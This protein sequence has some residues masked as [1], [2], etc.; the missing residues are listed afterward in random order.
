M[1]KNKL[2]ILVVLGCL[3]CLVGCSA[4]LPQRD[5]TIYRCAKAPEGRAAAAYTALDSSIYVFCGRSKEHIVNASILVYHADKDSW[6]RILTSIPPR[7]HPTATTLNGAIYFGLGYSGEGIYKDDAFLRDF[8]RYEPA[9]DTWTR[10]ADYPSGNTVAAISFTDGQDIYVGF[11]Y[12]NFTHELFHYSVEQNTWTQVSTSLDRSD[13]PPRVMSP[14]S[15]TVGQRYFVGTGHRNWV[16]SFLAE[17]LPASDSWEKRTPVPGKARHNAACTTTDDRLFVLGG[18]HYGDSLTNGFHFEDILAYDPD[19]DAW[20]SFG[21]MPCG[22][23]ENHIAATIGNTI[24]FGLG[25]DQHGKLIID[26][27]RFDVQ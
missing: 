8:Y 24:Y 14:I 9:T 5:V 2:G 11:G 19:N 10:L 3:G 4:D 26:L 7:V 1:W 21:T 20:S 27:Y 22:P 17:Y 16:G 15:G 12:H 23:A 6:S 25:E 13:Y 18:W